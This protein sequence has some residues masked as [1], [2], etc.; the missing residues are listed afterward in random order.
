MKGRLAALVGVFCIACLIVPGAF[1]DKPPKPEKPGRS[2]PECILFMGEDL[3]SAGDTTIVGCCP[4]AGPAPAYSLTL[5]TESR[6]DGT[7]QGSLFMNVLGTPGPD[8]KYMV[9]FWTWD[10]EKR[11][12][13]DGDYFFE[14][15][16]GVMDGGKKK[17][18]RPFTVTYT[19]EMATGWEYFDDAE[20]VRF[21]IPLVSFVLLRDSDLDYC[22]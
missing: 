22:E 12:P 21:D 8:Q 9:K 7:Y 19:D 3:Q 16:G 2:K 5:H 4:N 6:L 1:A 14:I 18:N 11:D 10:G 13:G 15:R 17:D 20:P